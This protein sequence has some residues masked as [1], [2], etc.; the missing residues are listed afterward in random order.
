MPE[1]YLTRAET[2]ILTEHGR[3]L[4]ALGPEPRTLVELGSGSSAK[5]RIL[6]DHLVRRQGGLR[7]VPVD[8]SPTALEKSSERLLADFPSLEIVALASEYRTGLDYVHEMNDQPRLILWLGSNIGNFERAGA[9]DFL[10]AIRAAMEAEDRLL[11]GV[12][13]RKDSVVLQRAYDDEQG[14][15][16]RFNLNILAHINRQLGG[17]FQLERFSHRAVYEEREGRIAMY[18]VSEVEQSVSIDH[19]QLEV[20]FAAGEAVHTEYSYKYSRQE[21]EQTTTT[22]GLGLVRHLLD[23]ENRFS[24][25]LF[26]PA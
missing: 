11:V 2:A 23:A 22:A 20:S 6:I 24:L 8:I 13:L 10:H 3:D 25:N 12:D 14:V 18:L 19:L 16:A 5:T 15:T 7:Y 9:A 17:H 21:I 1:Y 26:A 4:V